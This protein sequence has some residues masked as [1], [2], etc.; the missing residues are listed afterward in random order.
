MWVLWVELR[1]KWVELRRK[2]AGA[3]EESTLVS[4]LIRKQTQA[5]IL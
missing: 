4:R 5:S 2:P 1:R 3:A